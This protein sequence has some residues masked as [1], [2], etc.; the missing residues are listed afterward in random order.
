M[1]A[2]VA[3]RACAVLSGVGR[4]RPLLSARGFDYGS[5][6]RFF[7]A[8]DAMQHDDRQS[9]EVVVVPSDA[10]TA[11]R[12]ALTAAEPAGRVGGAEL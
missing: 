3:A 6:R 8:H 4:P 10:V 1:L 9:A 12:R 11:R 7:H 5:A 2:A